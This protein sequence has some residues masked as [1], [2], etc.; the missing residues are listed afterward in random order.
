MQETWARSLGWED[1]LEEGMATCSSVLAWR[2]PWTEGAG[3]LRSTGSHESDT[4]ERL[5]RVQH[6]M[7]CSFRA[8][9]CVCACSVMSDS[10]VTPWMIAR[11]APLSMEFSQQEYWSK[12]IIIIILEQIAVSFSRGSSQPRD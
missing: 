11:Q 8:C 3:G 1:P 9:V 2:I 4:T 5:R 6:M 7:A 10:L 12:K